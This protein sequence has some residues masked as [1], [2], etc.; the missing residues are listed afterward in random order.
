MLFYYRYVLDK[1]L[2]PK[3]SL[4]VATS[5]KPAPS[6]DLSFN[7]LRLTLTFHQILLLLPRGRGLG[8]LPGALHDV[9]NQMKQAIHNLIL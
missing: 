9:S 6:S 4:T 2:S 3:F 7:M 8:L 5:A 1:I